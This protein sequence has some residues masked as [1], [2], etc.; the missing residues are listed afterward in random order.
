MAAALPPT[1]TTA[2]PLVHHRD[3]RRTCTPRDSTP[4]SLEALMPVHHLSAHLGIWLSAPLAQRPRP[5]PP[6]W[7]RARPPLCDSRALSRASTTARR[8]AAGSPPL[9]TG[10]HA[11]R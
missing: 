8:G 4:T 1:S 11:R 7:R 9:T 6:T 10:G 2:A 5:G 3:R